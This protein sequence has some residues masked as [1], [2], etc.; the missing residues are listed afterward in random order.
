MSTPANEKVPELELFGVAA[1]PYVRKNVVVLK[2]KSL[3]YTFTPLN[4][5]GEQREELLK[6]NP[7]GKIPVLKVNGA[8]TYESADIN[9]S[10][11]EL[12]ASPTVYPVIQS[13]KPPLFGALAWV[14]GG[15]FSA[16]RVEAATADELSR[17]V[18]KEWSFMGGLASQRFFLPALFNKE[19][20]EEVVKQLEEK[21]V[22]KLQEFEKSVPKK[23]FALGKDMSVV[24]VGYG[25]WLRQVQ[26]GGFE[27]DAEKFPRIVA[28][29]EKLYVSPGWKE[30]IAWE[31]E[32]DLIKAMKEKLTSSF[33]KPV[34]E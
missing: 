25:T 24:D 8:P 27:I 30:T 9:T 15:M 7:L 14:P 18:D 2:Y 12:K 22:A 13:S 26:L 3:P 33:K 4:P 17:R 23:G 20:D 16:S 21:V 19:T 32:D 28:Y 10:I 34:I 31:N 29:L 11:E 6:M 5:F 1:S